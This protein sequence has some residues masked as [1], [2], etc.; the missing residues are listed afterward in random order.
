M[1][2]GL[3]RLIEKIS[4][5]ELFIVLGTKNYLDALRI[6]EVNILAQ[7]TIALKLNKPTFIMMNKDLSREEKLELEGYFNKHNVIKEMELDMRDTK[8]MNAAVKEIARIARRDV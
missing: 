5:S 8:Q 4:G 2:K 6:G 7:V 1:N 3:N